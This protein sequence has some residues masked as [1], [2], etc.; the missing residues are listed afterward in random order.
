MK[1]KILILIPSLEIGG[2]AEKV[3]STL[4]R[5]LKRDYNIH[6]LTFYDDKEKYPFEGE[7]HS[8][9][10]S[11]YSLKKLLLPVEIFITIREISPDIIISFLDHVNS[12]AILI[13]A[14]FRIK[15]PLIVCMHSNPLIYYQQ[16]DKFLNFFIR[17]LY[18]LK[19]VNKIITISR[20]IEKSL[21]R[22]Y[23][24]SYES[25]KTIYNGI[26][27]EYI[28][29]LKEEEIKGKIK[30][31]LKNP[32]LIKFITMGRLTPVKGHKYLI[33]AF[34][35]T[36]KAVSNTKLIIIG[37]GP[38]KKK[39]KKLV[40]QKNLNSDVIFA[41]LKKNPYKYLIKADIYVLSSITEGLP[42]ALIEAMA[43]SLPIISTDCRTGPREILNNGEYGIL[44]K[45]KDPDSLGEE[46]IKLAKNEE[47]RREYAKK[48]A[49]RVKYFDITRI[50]NVWKELIE[51]E[52]KS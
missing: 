36:K 44:T 3:A 10:L 28:N 27:L 35:K 17:F 18:P 5:K 24:I 31:T 15:I 39:L 32:N 50:K 2:G 37:E 30:T 25:L 29:Q 14:I 7:Y 13:K 6:I 9:N 47:L 45:I 21:N 48:S 26:D 51:K 40:A 33:K 19:Y 42:L 46:M 23:G 52:I 22:F 41:G 43:C 11:F 1:K 16:K 20:E 49:K 34:Y 12:L 8:L 38:R 4:T